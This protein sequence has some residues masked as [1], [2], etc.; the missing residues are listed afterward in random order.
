MSVCRSEQS[1]PA[2][3]LIVYRILWLDTVTKSS[4]MQGLMLSLEGGF[5]NSFQYFRASVLRMKS[6]ASVRELRGPRGG[7]QSEAGMF[8]ATQCRPARRAFTA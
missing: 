8:S 4:F 3:V 6:V 7:A 5:D 1:S 2:A